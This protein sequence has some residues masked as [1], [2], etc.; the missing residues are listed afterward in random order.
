MKNTFI[1]LTL[2]AASSTVMASTT[3]YDFVAMD[4][5]VQTQLCL[6]SAKEGLRAA[7]NLG[8]AKFK[9]D[10]LCNGQKIAQFAKQFEQPNTPKKTSVRYTVVAQDNN[11]ESLACAKAASEGLQALNLKPSQLKTIFCNG[12]NIKSFANS[13]FNI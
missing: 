3:K 6:V 4:D 2:L 7:K 11:S 13:F 5:S 9:N 1:A 12:Q 8:K 10:T